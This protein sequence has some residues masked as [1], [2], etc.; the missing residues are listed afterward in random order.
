MRLADETKINVG[1]KTFTLRPTLRAAVRLHKDYDGLQNLYAALGS[2]SVSA[3]LD[4]ISAACAD[5]R[6]VILLAYEIDKHALENSVWS[7][8]DQLQAFVLKLSGHDDADGESAST[9]KP[10]PY[11]EY[12]ARLFEIATGWLGWEP[13]AAWDAS[14]AEIL[15]AQKGRVELLRAVFGG[16]DKQVNEGVTPEL[17]AR[18]NALGDSTIH[19]MAQVP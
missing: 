9:G 1:S 17:R 4:L 8:R 19:T 18:L 11:E 13:N 7:I 2:G 10:I 5:P 16:D 6:L 3:C 14:P 15:A 12:F